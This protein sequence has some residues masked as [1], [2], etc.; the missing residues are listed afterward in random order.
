MR[1]KD[2]YMELVDDALSKG[3]SEE[4]AH[5]EAMSQLMLAVKREVQKDESGKQAAF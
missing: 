2:I 3:R 4:D 5:K 1:L